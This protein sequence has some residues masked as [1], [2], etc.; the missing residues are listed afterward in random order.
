MKKY[1]YPLLLASALTAVACSDDENIIDIIEEEVP[2]D[3]K[4]A[5][6]FTVSDLGATQQGSQ[7]RAGFSAATQIVA[8]F[9][10][11]HITT[12]A[13]RTTRSVLS[14]AAEIT[15][16]SDNTKFSK[17]D[18]SGDTNIRYWDDAFGRNA[19]I[20]VYAVAVP[21]KATAPANNGTQFT[22]LISYAGSQVSDSNTDWKT[23]D[24]ATNND[25]SW[26]VTKG[27]SGTTITGQT[28][29]L[30]GNED[31][32]YSNNIQDDGNTTA[33]NDNVLGI[34]G[35]YVYDFAQ[36]KYV[37]DENGTGAETHK[38]GPLRIALRTSDD[39]TSN[40]RF[41]KGHLVF[42]HALTRLVVTLTEGTDDGYSS[43]TEVTDF[44][45]TNNSNIKLLQFPTSGKLNIKTGTW[46]DYTAD[47]ITD[48]EQMSGST[49]A[50]A[51]DY[52]AQMLPGYKFY[53][54]GDN[55]KKNVMQFVIDDN[56]YFITQKMVF[57]ALN[58]SDNTG[59][60]T[61][62]ITVQT[63]TDS[64]KYIE[65][66]Q[67]KRY[68]LNITVK[69]AKIDNITATL[70]EW[71][72]VTGSTSVSN[73]HI[74]L[75]L[76]TT[77]QTCDKDIDLY[78]LG[79]DNAGYDADKFDFSYKGKNWF[80]NYTTD[81]KH[82]TTLAHSAIKSDNTWTTPW[83][84]ESN[85]TYY[86]FRTVNSGTTILGNTGDG[87]DVTNDYFEITAGPTATT[88]PHWGAPM[89][90]VDGQTWLQY[91]LSKGYENHLHH[92]IGATK[93]QIA[94]QELHMMSNIEVILQTPND[95]SKVTF[96]DGTNKTVVKIT[97]LSTKG[98][99]E[100]GRGLVTPIAPKN[101]SDA[102]DYNDA[103]AEV[104]MTAPETYFTTD[105]L[106]TGNYTYA[107]VPQ[108]LNRVADS[109]SDDD[110]VGIFIQTPDQNQYY[111]VKKLSE[112]L[113]ST[114]TDQR[115]Q[116]QGQKITRWY[117]GHKYIY[118]F[119]ISKK[120]IENITCTVA[121]WVTVTGEDIKIDL[122]S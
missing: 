47:N 119:T 9:E 11:K 60:T 68:H 74:S 82:K 31:L 58:I 43:S 61:P 65:M 27:S 20:S 73:E 113:A 121:D 79:D 88:D 80:G 66:E 76:K 59:G 84:F 40:G 3:Q 39:K 2:A 71:N 42:K 75:T 32:C 97:R 78:R 114:V 108:V 46:Y 37:P 10:S 98:Q 19:L 49:T 18:Y 115:D 53:G 70:L 69:K 120:G 77:G 52:S 111:V 35:R 24:A 104:T 22:D 87:A 25:I 7:T 64:K 8:R 30:I 101:S 33:D 89:Q 23:G 99:V 34:N 54:D 117:P 102:V 15:N 6:A 57:D 36:N 122:E 4:Q 67:G 55:A 48:I 118:T 112:I 17:V 92:A 50:A 13:V 38:P 1:I 62:K 95:G 116:T 63:D 21:N 29:E 86:H 51:G 56:T 28:D 109:E 91:D 94:I 85:K 105:G 103:S 83:Y 16:S 14:A 90:A 45:F 41:D 93:D 26:T 5:I 72:E 96:D 81:A 110:Y 44:Q 100:M 12:K 107:V 106:V